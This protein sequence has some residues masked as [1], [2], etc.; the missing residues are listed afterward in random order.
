MFKRKKD[1]R[2][3]ISC[4]SD[5]R[6]WSDRTHLHKDIVDIVCLLDHHLAGWEISIGDSINLCLASEVAGDS[7]ALTELRM[8]VKLISKS[9][10]MLK[11][12]KIYL[13]V[14]IL[15]IWKLTEGWLCFKSAWP[16][17]LAVH[18][19]VTGKLKGLICAYKAR[20]RQFVR[21]RAP[22]AYGDSQARA[23]IDEPIEY[24][25]LVI[26]HYLCCGVKRINRTKKLNAFF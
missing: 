10:N 11:I 22:L 6:S 3:N 5:A 13:D 24:L 21:D 9:T 19:L 17:F 7:H 8:P 25:H 20:K 23:G 26:F 14:A 15:H 1:K 18:N 16:N 12:I 2:K 4:V